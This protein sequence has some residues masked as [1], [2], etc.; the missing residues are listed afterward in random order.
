MSLKNYAS[1]CKDQLTELKSSLSQADIKELAEDYA[2]LLNQQWVDWL[3]Q[4][5]DEI[6][7]FVRATPA[8]RR[9]K[10]KWQDQTTRLRLTLA[11]IFHLMQAEIVLNT[12]HEIH[13]TAG[14]SYR[15]MAANAGEAYNRIAV[16]PDIPL[17][18]F[19]RHK[20]LFCRKP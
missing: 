8:A 9:A 4:H 20:E 3:G 1:A 19:E 10:K 5:E 16:D 2:C 13:L 12:L 6:A 15:D 7:S 14:G 17:W 18:P 11:A